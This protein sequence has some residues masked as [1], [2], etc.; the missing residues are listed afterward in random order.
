[1]TISI[2]EDSLYLYEIL[3]GGGAAITYIGSTFGDLIDFLIIPSTV[4][5]NIV[6]AISDGGFGTISS[7]ITSV[8]FP[9]TLTS[10]GIRAFEG[11]TGTIDLSN[12][13]VTTVGVSAFSSASSVTYP[14]SFNTIVDGT[15][16][17]SLNETT[18]E[19][20][21]VDYHLNDLNYIGSI[22]IPSQVSIDATTTYQVVKWDFDSL[23]E[24]SSPN[25]VS[26]HTQVELNLTKYLSIFSYDF[27]NEAYIIYFDGTHDCMLTGSLTGFTGTVYYPAGN[28]TWSSNIATLFPDANTMAVYKDDA[29]SLLYTLDNDEIPTYAIAQD[30]ALFT[31]NERTMI[32]IPGVVGGINVLYVA[33][34]SF[35]ILSI[36]SYVDTVGTIIVPTTLAYDNMEIHAILSYFFYSI[37]MYRIQY[38]GHYIYLQNSYDAFSYYVIPNTTKVVLIRYTGATPAMGGWDV[39]IPYQVY[40][41]NPSLGGTEALKVVD[42]IGFNAFAGMSIKSLTFHVDSTISY[43]CKNAFIQ[44]NITGTITFPTTLVK[45]GES[46]FKGNQI[47]GVVFSNHISTIGTACFEGMSSLSTVS[48][49]S[50]LTSSLNRGVSLTI[51][52]RAFSG[53]HISSLVFPE[54]LTTLGK[55]VFSYNTLSSVTFPGSISSIGARCFYNTSSL[56][57]V[58]FPS[59]LN[60]GVSLTIGTAA[61]SGC[62]IS[63]VVLTEGLTTLG[64]EAF[65]NLSDLSSVTLPSTLV[66][67]GPLA[68]AAGPITN[69][70]L[71]T[72]VG[73]FFGDAFPD[74]SGNIFS[75]WQTGGGPF[76]ALMGSTWGDTFESINVIKRFFDDSGFTY[77]VNGTHATILGKRGS[78]STSLTIPGT[79]TI[80]GT[81][82]VVNTIAPHA[83]EN[84]NIFS[85]TL[86]ASM[87]T[88]GAYAFYGNSLQSL[89]IPASVTSIGAAAFYNNEWLSAVY[90]EGTKVDEE[91]AFNNA[92][93][94]TYNDGFEINGS[95]IIIKSGGSPYICTVFGYV[96]PY[97]TSLTIPDSFVAGG[98][99]YV[100]TI[101]YGGAFYNMGLVS[102]TLPSTHPLEINESA[103]SHNQLTTLVVP[104]SV[105]SLGVNSFFENPLTSVTFLGAPLSQA[106]GNPFTNVTTLR[107]IVVN[108]PTAW[109]GDYF[110]IPLVRPPGPLEINNN[111]TVS[112]P[113]P[114]DLYVEAFNQSIRLA[115]L[116]S[117]LNIDPLSVDVS[118]TT[119]VPMSL[120]GFRSVFQFSIED[121]AT[122]GAS[123]SDNITDLHFYINDASLSSIEMTYDASNIAYPGQNIIRTT[124]LTSTHGGKPITTFDYKRGGQLPVSQ[125]NVASDFTRYLATS[126]FGTPAGV[127][128][129]YNEQ[130]IITDITEQFERAWVFSDLSNVL[131]PISRGH[132]ILIENGGHMQYDTS[133]GCYMDNSEPATDAHPYNISQSLFNQLLDLAPARFSTHLPTGLIQDL[134]AHQPQALPFIAGDS[135]SWVLSVSPAA[136]QE[137]LV[138]GTMGIKTRT[139]RIKMVLQ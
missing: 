81:T 133:Y 43:I 86:P 125:M 89:V 4:D 78:T 113:K 44:N 47:S 49:P 76:Y 12:T 39:T 75:G 119:V 107:S 33:P 98:H 97:T 82:Y 135:I 40:D 138:T 87:T 90:F 128:L 91:R 46:A 53:C 15:N 38:D 96:G 74:P 70:S 116:A 52:D 102:L 60:T 20:T 122:L 63:S 136:G 16:V 7:S 56:S 45:V 85:L 37:Q 118:C 62:G 58:T 120:A 65:Y 57:T 124:D 36:Q 69:S 68:F 1:M 84:K 18:N 22:V 104:A 110:G 6:V 42:I 127:D 134:Q 88:I 26:I 112:T 51:E 34:N 73:Y 14:A 25:L 95:F 3:N 92:N 100:L 48:F 64:E 50:A 101:I 99:T 17:Y 80:T 108:N 55:G 139:Y 11:F 83:F 131:L 41:S 106:G 67:V 72:P 19:L 111:I 114:V 21:V 5:G 77:T 109:G 123:P 29:T 23:K 105:T 126:I 132:G 71:S 32:T 121:I 137:S 27:E 8:Y 24:K 2:S 117:L 115:E 103:F 130:A 28:S 54:G 10:I 35:Q 31:H 129:F 93:T 66:S 9:A 61:F 13:A 30:S 94:F 59:S 79:V